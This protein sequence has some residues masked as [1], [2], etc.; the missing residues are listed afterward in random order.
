[1]TAVPTRAVAVPAVVSNLAGGVALLVL[2]EVIGRLQLF[3]KNWPP[4]TDVVAYVAGSDTMQATLVRAFGATATS[5]LTGFA[6]G[7]VVGGAL[8]CVTVV[9]KWTA[10][11][12]DRLATIVHAVPL[13]AIAP[14]LVSTV[15]RVHTAT[16]VAAMG[17]GFA[18]FVATSAGLA[19]TPAAQSDVHSALGSSRWSRL[20]YLQLPHTAPLVTDGAGLAVTAAVLGAVLGEWFGAPKGLGVL[21]VSAMNNYQ[22]PLLWAAAIGCVVLSLTAYSIVRLLAVPVHRR[23]S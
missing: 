2:F 7:A 5:A 19:S 11:G 16:V 20:R 10:P 8:A 23:F 9:A 22:I 21:L 6:L 4:L 12:L 3:G 14:L 17:A 1:M 15:G 13:I 18:I